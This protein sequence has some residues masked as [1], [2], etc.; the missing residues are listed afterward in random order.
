MVFSTAEVQEARLFLPSLGALAV[1]VGLGV[2]ALAARA[3][4]P[5]VA[6]LTL[7]AL[8]VPLGRSITLVQSIRRPVTMDVA[9]DWTLANV[10]A[11][12]K[13]FTSVERLGLDPARY[14]VTRALRLGP[15][16]R[17][18]ALHADL[19]VASTE[20]DP[21]VVAELRT[22]FV[23]APRDPRE[24]PVI[25]LL[26]PEG[27]APVYTY[28]DLGRARLT[29]SEQPELLDCLRDGDLATSWSSDGP[30]RPGEFVQVELEAPVVLGRIDL[31][32]GDK[33]VR[34]SDNLHV[35]VSAD[36]H[37]WR[38]VRVLPGRPPVPEQVGARSQVLLIDPVRVL[39]VRIVQQGRRHRRWGIAELRLGTL[40]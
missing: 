13:V 11:G 39:G 31:A 14:E 32:L 7:A 5:F 3:R 10:P 15:S 18:Q 12:A 35:L 29:A 19:I 2:E 28:A 22:R 6:A 36:R 21:A 9:L 33:N 23:A 1:L 38:R 4:P 8:A 30:Q 34:Y 37:A 25:L 26:S 27:L 24:G 40:Q 16:T 17:L 20:D